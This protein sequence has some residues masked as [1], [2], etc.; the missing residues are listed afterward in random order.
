VESR[1]QH[2]PRKSG[3]GN[4]TQIVAECG[5]VRREKI[6]GR[7]YWRCDPEPSVEGDIEKDVEWILELSEGIE[8]PRR[9]RT[10][11]KIIGWLDQGFPYP[12]VSVAGGLVSERSDGVRVESQ[13]Q[14]HVLAQR[15]EAAGIVRPP[16]R[17]DSAD[18]D[19][20]ASCAVRRPTL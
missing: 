3:L 1:Y 5:I 12:E 16:W 14:D 15:G 17:R 7:V 2:V 18:I 10:G 4:G 13:G 8:A 20:R 6:A 19:R 11:Q 9:D